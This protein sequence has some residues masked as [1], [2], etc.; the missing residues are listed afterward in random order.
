MRILKNIELDNCAIVRCHCINGVR[1]LIK[2]LPN[3][4]YN[5]DG[6]YIKEPEILK[7]QLLVNYNSYINEAKCRENIHLYAENIS[8]IFDVSLDGIKE[9]LYSLA[10][11]KLMEKIGGV[12]DIKKK[13]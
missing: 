8:V 2:C 11:K 10:Y 6:E 1:L 7:Y 5:E 3:F 13:K 4:S 12:S 9:N